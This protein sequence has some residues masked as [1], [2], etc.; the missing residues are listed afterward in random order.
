MG[1]KSTLFIFKLAWE[2]IH[3]HIL[4][5]LCPHEVYLFNLFLVMKKPPEASFEKSPYQNRVVTFSHI[6]FV[7]MHWLNQWDHGFL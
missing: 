5:E 2:S 3:D 6:T 1:A 4:S 7:L